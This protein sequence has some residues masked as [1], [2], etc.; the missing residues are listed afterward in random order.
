MKKVEY[1][2]TVEILYWKCPYVRC[3]YAN[4]DEGNPGEPGSTVVCHKCKRES[5]LGEYF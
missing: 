2:E 3:G 5:E 1:Y 4:E